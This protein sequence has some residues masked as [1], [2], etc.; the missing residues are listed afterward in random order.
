MHNRLTLRRLDG[1]CEKTREA[2]EN[3][4][5]G[6]RE[7]ESREPGSMGILENDEEPK[8][9]GI[10]VNCLSSTRRADDLRSGRCAVLELGQMYG[11]RSF[12]LLK[13]VFRSDPVSGE[14][15]AIPEGYHLDHNEK[16]KGKEKK[17]KTKEKI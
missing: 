9:R 13:K 6:R 3:G 8:G 11:I 17:R 1:G 14:A 7:R 4:D 2:E 12:F 15:V 5:K 10:K 16:W